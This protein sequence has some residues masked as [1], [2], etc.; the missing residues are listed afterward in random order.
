MTIRDLLKKRQFELKDGDLPPSRAA[1][2]L[3]ELSS[4]YGNVLDEVTNREMEFNKVMQENLLEHKAATKAR[5]AA[6]TT[7]EYRS[8]LI[9]K[10]AEKL[11]VE[12]TRSLKYYLKSKEQEYKEA[13][14]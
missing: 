6:E 1:E 5:I 3:V 9:A 12:M 4:L 10:N 2:I 8:L 11:C 13:K 7:D 14:Y